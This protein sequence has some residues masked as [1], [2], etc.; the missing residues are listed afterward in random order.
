VKVLAIETA[1]RVTSVALI[2]DKGTD[3]EIAPDVILAHTE[4][5]P[6]LIMKVLLKDNTTLQEID[7]FAVSI[8]PGSFTGIRVGVTTARTLGQCL[9]KPVIGIPTLDGLIWSERE[10]DDLGCPM[11]DAL[12]NAVY[13]TLFHHRE[14]LMDYHLA[15]IHDWLV[16]LKAKNRAVY[17][18]GDGAQKYHDLIMEQLGDLATF[19]LPALNRARAR[20]IAKIALD[21]LI[22]G[23]TQSYKDTMPLYIRRSDAEEK[24][25]QAEQA[26]SISSSEGLVLRKMTSQ[27]L[28]QIQE[29]EK[30]SF[31]TPWEL[32]LFMGELKLP[33]AHFY[34][35]EEH[36][37]IIGYCGFWLGEQEAHIVTLA[38]CQEKRRKGLGSM[39]VTRMLE[40]AKPL[41]ATRAVLEVRV[42]NDPAIRLYEKCGFSRGAIHR[43]YYGDN[44]EDALTMLRDIP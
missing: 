21:K 35:L 30:Q 39:L 24:R 3:I 10:S 4:L 5:L 12:R 2:D 34:V 9:G 37:K 22:A 29:I 11:I 27:D 15:D 7:A 41:G 40:Q 13:T 31:S 1:T 17:F 43:K 25:E 38:I 6:E 32:Q 33:F 36:K 8:G 26:T 28:P 42:S 23:E 44:D 18:V 19:A 14:R 20:S 16:E